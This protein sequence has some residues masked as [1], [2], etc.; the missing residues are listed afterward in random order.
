MNRWEFIRLDDLT[1]AL[2]NRAFPHEQT[3]RPR[4]P[5]LGSVLKPPKDEKKVVPLRHKGDR[6]G[7][8][9]NQRFQ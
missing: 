3:Q 1:P 2:Q 7:L 5:R 8:M 4:H 9:L 6:E